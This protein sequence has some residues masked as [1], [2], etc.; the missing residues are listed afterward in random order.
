MKNNFI[1]LDS[2]T[3]QQDMR[4]RLPK[5]VLANM[6]VEKGKTKFDIFF[7][8]E[9]CLIS[10]DSLQVDVSFDAYDYSE[11]Q[12]HTLSLIDSHGLKKISPPRRTEKNCR[13]CC[14]V[15]TDSVGQARRGS[16]DRASRSRAQ[17]GHGRARRFRSAPCSSRAVRCPRWL[18]TR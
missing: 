4:I 1:Y 12:I 5:S 8:K 10:P 2:Y 13:L 16:S 7:D 9:N 3:L 6:N 11:G 17:G 15:I 18:H 14:E